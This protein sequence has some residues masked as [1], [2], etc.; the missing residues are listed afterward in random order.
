MSRLIVV[1]AVL[2]T[3]AC[4]AP[5]TPAE[6]ARQFYSTLDQRPFD[7][8]A[9]AALFDPAYVDHD[10]PAGFPASVSDREALVGLGRALVEGFPD[11]VHRL[12]LVREGGEGF[13]TAYWTFTGTNTGPFLGQP[14]TGRSI[15]I[16]G[17]DVLR[18]VNGK[19]AEQWHVE[20]LQ[21]LERQLAGR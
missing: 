8:D 4:G 16:N 20:E 5:P 21:L 13:V 3:T 7:A 17:I 6:L 12:D 14:A 11:G 1:A 15:S 10:R 2:L 18:F 9:L 19:V